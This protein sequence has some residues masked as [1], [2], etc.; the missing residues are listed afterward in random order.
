MDINQQN[1]REYSKDRHFNEV[2]SLGQMLQIGHGAEPRHWPRTRFNTSTH[3]VPK[4]LNRK[5]L[6]DGRSIFHEWTALLP[7][8][9]SNLSIIRTPI[10]TVCVDLFEWLLSQWL[11]DFSES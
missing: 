6:E 1:I 4:L 8:L 11:S 7:N 3:H 10:R 5:A 9:D 2:H